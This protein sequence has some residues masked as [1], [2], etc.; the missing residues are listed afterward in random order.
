MIEGELEAKRTEW[1]RDR[2]EA[3]TK[4]A[5]LRDQ[6]AEVKEQRERLVAAGEDGTCPTCERP[7]HD[8]YRSVLDHFDEQM[9]NLI[10]DGKYFT[11]RIEQLEEMP[12]EVRELDE[13]RRT[14]FED[15][16]KLER[17]LAKVQLAVQELSGLTRDLH[18]REQRYAQVRKDREAIPAGYDAARHVAARA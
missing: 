17:R 16:G 18:A 1:V 9:D 7:L 6:Y 3:E 5:A 14:T 4:R 15:V 2:Q 12:A 13:R 8:H 10:A 11:S